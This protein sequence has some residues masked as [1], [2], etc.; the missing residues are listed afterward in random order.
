MTEI[1]SSTRS[2]KYVKKGRNMKGKVSYS[3][4]Y[5]VFYQRFYHLRISEM[6]GKYKKGDMGKE[7][8]YSNTIN[9]MKS[10]NAENGMKKLTQQYIRPV[11]SPLHAS[12]MK[13]KQKGR[14]GERKKKRSLIEYRSSLHN[15]HASTMKRKRRYKEKGI[16]YTTAI[17]VFT[18]SQDIKNY[19]KKK[20][21]DP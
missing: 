18:I 1:H 21:K 14:K 20:K 4:H 8:N 9:E 7:N 2:V 6:K 16:K 15:V 10:R 19:R 17:N 13:G 12:R 5:I 3:I 11:S